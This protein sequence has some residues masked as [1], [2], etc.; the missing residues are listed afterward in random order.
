MCLT[1][2]HRAL[3][4]D[5]M[6]VNL[7]VVKSQFNQ[8]KKKEK[9]KMCTETEKGEK[10]LKR[11]KVNKQIHTGLGPRAPVFSPKKPNTIRNKHKTEIKRLNMQSN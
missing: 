6:L 9:R 8:L 3:H 10:K 11:L 1:S 7:G 4:A 2:P 5:Y